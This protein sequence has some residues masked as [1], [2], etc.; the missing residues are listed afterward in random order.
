MLRIIS[1]EVIVTIVTHYIHRSI[2]LVDS[3]QDLSAWLA[4][5]GAV[6][7][8]MMNRTSLQSRL[9]VLLSSPRPDVLEDYW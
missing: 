1:R 2:T 8:D 9:D 6:I 5:N 3:L 4:D 7:D